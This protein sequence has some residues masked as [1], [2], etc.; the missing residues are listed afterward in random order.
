MGGGGGGSGG[1]GRYKPN[2]NGMFGRKGQ[3]SGRVRNMSGGRQGAKKFFENIS[4]GYIKEENIIGKGI[5]RTLSDGTSITYRW[6][7][8]DGTAVIDINNG[9]TY[10]EQKIH[11]ID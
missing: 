5:V 1:D 7:S 9:I 6:A 11:F 4:K 2:K 3:G 10:L 8:K